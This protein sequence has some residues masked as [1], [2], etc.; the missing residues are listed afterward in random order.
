M[1]NWKLVMLGGMALVMAAC[2]TPTQPRHSDTSAC[3]S[4]YSVQ[5]GDKCQT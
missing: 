3:R 4:G 5:V 1:R 2:S